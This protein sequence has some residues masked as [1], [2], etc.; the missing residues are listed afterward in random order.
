MN[1]RDISGSS[2]FLPPAPRP[3]QRPSDPAPQDVRSVDRQA[4]PSGGRPLLTGEEKQFFE[5]VFPEAKRDIRAFQAY[6][7]RGTRPEGGA[8]G[9]HVDRKA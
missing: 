7:G 6:T 2:P 4:E 5:S 1:I 3:A 9:I 8:T